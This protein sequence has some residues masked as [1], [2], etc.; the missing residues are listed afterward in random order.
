MSIPV[1]PNDDD[2]FICRTMDDLL[3]YVDELRSR[4]AGVDAGRDFLF[5]C[6]DTERSAA[7]LAIE[8]LGARLAKAE[9]LLHSTRNMWAIV[10]QDAR[11]TEIM[12]RGH[13][14]MSRRQVQSAR[15]RA[16]GEV[17]RID[18]HLARNSHHE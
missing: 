1:S 11:N 15:D 4:L 6:R 10:A 12:D 17:D 14:C 13:S 3:A 7:A 8:E 16:L 18:A 9:A 2:E 5:T